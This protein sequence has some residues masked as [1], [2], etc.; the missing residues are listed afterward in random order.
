MARLARPLQTHH[1]CCV[2]L[3]CHQTTRTRLATRKSRERN[4]LQAADVSNK[5]K[6]LQS[7]ILNHTVKSDRRRY[8]CTP[9]SYRMGTLQNF[10]RLSETYKRIFWLT[11]GTPIS[12][13]ALLQSSINNI[14]RSIVFSC[15]KKTLDLL[16]LMLE[17]VGIQYVRIDGATPTIERNRIIKQFQEDPETN[18]LLMTTGTGAVG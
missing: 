1:S 3:V 12:V 8:L 14:E 6:L 5:S 9:P 10:L 4:N 11:K 13:K 16:E 18:L 2:L 7:S 15:W 17:N